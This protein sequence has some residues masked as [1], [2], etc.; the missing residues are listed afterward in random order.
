MMGETQLLP[1]IRGYTELFPFLWPS[2]GSRVLIWALTCEPS[3]LSLSL[4]IQ[5]R[6]L[7]SPRPPGLESRLLHLSAMPLYECHT[8][9]CFLNC[10]PIIALYQ[11]LRGTSVTAAPKN[12]Q[13]SLVA[14]GDALGLG[15]RCLK[16]SLPLLS[17][18]S[19]RVRCSFFCRLLPALQSGNANNTHPLKSG[20]R[21]SEL[22]SRK[23][24]EPCLPE[25]RGNESTAVPSDLCASEPGTL[26]LPPGCTLGSLRR[27]G[28]KGRPSSRWASIATRLPSSWSLHWMRRS[29]DKSQS[30]CFCH[31]NS[32][33]QP[34]LI[35]PCLGHRF[36]QRH[37]KLGGNRV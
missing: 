6:N 5:G 19:L 15:D 31:L 26:G 12:T 4:K 17:S 27:L 28:K 32:A 14:Q 3:L 7:A 24:S 29:R 33:E 2:K 21:F 34:R 35:S 1:S 10:K 11:L 36:C 22:P 13:H 9:L 18:A 8:S 37:S 30:I 23:P 16:L 25:I 20:Y